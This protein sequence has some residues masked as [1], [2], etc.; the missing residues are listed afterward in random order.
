[1]KYHGITVDQIITQVENQNE[2]KRRNIRSSK[3]PSAF[4]FDV[5]IDDSRG[6]QIEAERYHFKVIVVDPS[7]YD[8]SEKIKIEVQA[9][10]DVP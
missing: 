1:M 7:D 9:F 3:F 5:H 2:L 8:W 4:G 6:V 10:R